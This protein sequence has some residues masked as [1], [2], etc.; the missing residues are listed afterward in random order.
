MPTAPSAP[1]CALSGAVRVRVCCLVGARLAHPKA[2]QLV[3]STQ[4]CSVVTLYVVYVACGDGAACCR[5]TAPACAVTLPSGALPITVWVCLAWV[6]ELAGRSAAQQ[7]FFVSLLAAS[8]LFLGSVPV[9]CD[10]VA[11]GRWWRA[12]GRE[13]RPP[14]PLLGCTDRLRLACL[15]LGSLSCCRH[16]C[17]LSKDGV[18]T[19]LD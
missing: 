13:R 5:Q 7:L 9:R 6:R 11:P 19:A 14:P 16:L 3:R 1:C 17:P 18:L 12:Q 8:C 4:H 2:G 10:C 15:A